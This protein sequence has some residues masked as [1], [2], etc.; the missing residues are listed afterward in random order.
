[1]EFL[2]D[3]SAAHRGVMGG[4]RTQGT[5]AE[6]WDCM[7]VRGTLRGIHVGGWWNPVREAIW[8]FAGVNMMNLSLILPLNEGN[9]VN[10][11]EVAKTL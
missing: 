6:A 5:A 7:R 2:A 10:L 3:R 9:G 8:R 1:M 11:E 4:S